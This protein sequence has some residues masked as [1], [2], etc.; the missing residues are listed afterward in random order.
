M[1]A[2]DAM[3][4]PKRE[5]R[6]PRPW[7]LPAW[8]TSLVAFLILWEGASV[9]AGRN[10]AGANTVPSLPDIIGATKL[11]GNYW[12]GGF[13]LERTAAGAELTWKAAILAFF[14]NS[15]LTILRTEIGLLLGVVSG[16]AMAA[17]VSWSP[18][19]RKT[20]TFPA[21]IARMLPLLALVPLFNLWLGN[22]ETAVLLFVGL[23]GFCVMFAATLGAIG[24]VPSY[25]VDYA[26]SL[27]VGPARVYLTV[28]LPAAQP[29]MN[30]GIQLAHGFAWS[31]VIAAEFLGMQFGL[32]RIVLMAQEFNQFSLLALAGFITVGWA[33]ATSALLTRVLNLLTRWI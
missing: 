5:T 25:Y 22:T 21:H 20:L 33:V 8:L 14:Y 19:L 28:V 11:L 27:G 13:G 3:A 6:A 32:G 9:L 29:R 30:V 2:A 10:A 23:V 15:G 26:R 24:A 4:E 31:A 16:V 12:P 18:F 1:S 7:P 17:A